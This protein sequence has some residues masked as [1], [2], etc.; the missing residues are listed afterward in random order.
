MFTGWMTVEALREGLAGHFRDEALQ[1]FLTEYLNSVTVHSVPDSVIEMQRNN[2]IASFRITAESHG[3][4]FDE[5]IMLVSGAS[6]EEELAE[7][8]EE[9]IRSEA[10]FFIVLQAVAED[11]GIEPTLDDVMEF[12]IN[13]IGSDDITMFEEVYGLP[14][15]KK[16]ALSEIVLS[17]IRDHMVFE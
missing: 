2:L 7:M 14:Y 8:H 17:H 11:V 10:S 5:Y 6:S 13:F 3:M 15:L 16:I 9:D 1:E 4:D 12:F